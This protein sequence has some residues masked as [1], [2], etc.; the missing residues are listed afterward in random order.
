METEFDHFLILTVSLSLASLLVSKI[1]RRR[2][3][4]PELCDL[5]VARISTPRD[6]NRTLFRRVPRRLV[7]FMG[8]SY[9]T[10]CWDRFD[11]IRGAKHTSR[12]AGHPSGRRQ[13][14]IE[15]DAINGHNVPSAEL[16]VQR[17][18]LYQIKS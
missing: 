5:F 3:V 15:F 14:M 10:V 8:Q 9:Q 6:P 7:R 17:P 11:F 2:V 4:C 13:M 1:E 12:I 16:Y 18:V